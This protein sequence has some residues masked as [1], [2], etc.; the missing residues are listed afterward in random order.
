MVLKFC[1]IVL[2]GSLAASGGELEVRL[3]KAYERLDRSLEASPELLETYQPEEETD[4]TDPCTDAEKILKTLPF[5]EFV[6]VPRP[7]QRSNGG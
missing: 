6:K 1:L 4:I 5:V 3:V 2:C 7:E